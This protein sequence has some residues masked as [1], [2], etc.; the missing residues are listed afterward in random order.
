MNE[1]LDIPMNSRLD[2]GLPENPFDAVKKAFAFRD[3]GNLLI[4]QVTATEGAPVDHCNLP[5]VLFFFFSFFI[6][7]NY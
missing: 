1:F 3:L 5:I 4:E 6:R 2:L 7:P